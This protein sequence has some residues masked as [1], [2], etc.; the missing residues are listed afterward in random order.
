MVNKKSSAKQK[1]ATASSKPALTP[2]T[3]AVSAFAPAALNLN[4]FASVVLGLDAYRLRIHDTNT[5]RL[6]CE[7]V[8][9]KG[10]TIGALS[11]GVL[12]A[13]DKKLAPKKKRK[14][15]AG[16]AED[17]A[18]QAGSV[19]VAAATNR[20]SVLMFSPSEAQMVG[21]LEGEHVGAVKDFE[22]VSGEEGRG[23]S[24]G[25][26]G[27]LVLWDTVAKVSLR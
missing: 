18:E 11:W 19:V 3:L 2:A 6:R 21:T 25:V 15:V 27:K 5:G 23:W 26:D 9:E 1:P 20:G 13:K 8:F 16:E 17:D 4:L 10:V 7:H 22:F 24:C 12:P 14:R